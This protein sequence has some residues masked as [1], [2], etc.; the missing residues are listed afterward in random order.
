MVYLKTEIGYSQLVVFYGTHKMDM[1]KNGV[2]LRW[3]LNFL[4]NVHF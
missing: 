3:D 2:L 4:Y 1:Y